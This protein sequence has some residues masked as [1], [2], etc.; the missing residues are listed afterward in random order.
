MLN[1]V[2]LFVLTLV[3]SFRYFSTMMINFALNMV[4]NFAF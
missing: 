3:L 4:I 1:T 2:A